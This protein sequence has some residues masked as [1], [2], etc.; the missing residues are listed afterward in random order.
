LF[1]AARRLQISPTDCWYV[2][3][4]LRDIDAGKAAGMPTIAAGWGYCGN[5]EPADWLADLIASHPMEL[6]PLLPRP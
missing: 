6:L 1:E 5:T 2:G 4:D 3:D